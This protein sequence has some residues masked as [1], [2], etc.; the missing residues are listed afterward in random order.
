MIP[1]PPRDAYVFSDR[2]T[3][4]GC[5]APIVWWITPTGKRSPHDPD[6]TS[7]FATCPRRSDFRRGRAQ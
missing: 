6:G 7:H 3:C 2:G 5:G 1:D 4:R